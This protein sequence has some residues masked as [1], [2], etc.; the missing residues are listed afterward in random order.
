MSR[1]VRG[2]PKLD[3]VQRWIR[4]SYW[5]GGTSRGLILQPKE[6]PRE[7]W[8]WP[9]LFAQLMGSP[10]PYGRQLDGMGAGLS[11][12]S[13]I[14]LVEPSVAAARNHERASD[15]D[16]TFVNMGVKTGTLDVAGNCGNMLSAIGPYAYAAKLLPKH[17][18]QDG[19]KD[20]KS[21]TVTIRNTNTG[22]LIKSTFSTIGDE[23]AV[24]GEESVD[25]VAGTG[26]SIALEFLNPSGSK[27]GKLLPTGNAVDDIL[28]YKVSCVDGAIP[29]VYIRADDI[30]IDGAIMPTDFEAQTEKLEKL[31][32]IRRAAAVAMGLAKIESEVARSQPKIG[33]VSKPSTH[34]V[35]SGKSIAS[36]EVDLVVRFISDGQPH[37]AIPLTAALTTAL[38]AKLPSVVQQAAGSV[39]VTEGVLTIGHASGR[40]P[41]KAKFE[42][43]AGKEHSATVFRTAKRIFEGRLYYNGYLG[44][45]DN[46]HVGPNQDEPL[47]ATF[48]EEMRNNEFS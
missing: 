34:L 45:E 17:F 44:Q 1:F 23:P 31:E 40:I 12:L 29:A 8:T 22:Q 7:R 41:V 3:P 18:Y 24:L 46:N 15:I 42:G 21:S 27:T 11:S 47:G 14:C 20:V 28:G 39:P 10:D 43:D 16:Y 13:K 38:A 36:S 19:E 33:L 4:G 2:T 35:L 6:L 30:G 25:G 26:A 32:Q 48:V 37:R 9:P 5:R